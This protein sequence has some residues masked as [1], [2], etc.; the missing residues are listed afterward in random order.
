[1]H[2]WRWCWRQLRVYVRP[3]SNREDGKR[4]PLGDL[5]IGGG[6]LGDFR[7][8]YCDALLTAVADVRILVFGGIHADVLDL[9]KL[10]LRGVVNAG[11]LFEIDRPSASNH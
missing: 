8:A 11:G 3:C 4:D 10:H 2:L 9:D 7:F 5:T 6:W 1:M